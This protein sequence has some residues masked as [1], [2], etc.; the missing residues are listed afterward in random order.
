MHYT[1]DHMI[2]DL[3][4]L[5]EKKERKMLD[6]ILFKNKVLPEKDKPLIKL[7]IIIFLFLFFVFVTN[8][9]HIFASTENPP[10]N[11]GIFF[12]MPL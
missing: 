10:N 7:R 6:K 5:V 11:A 4:P 3:S 2:A 8:K 12:C 1:S 9:K